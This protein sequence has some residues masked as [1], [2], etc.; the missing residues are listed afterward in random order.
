[1]GHYRE[2]STGR[3]LEAPLPNK[4]QKMLHYIP[5]LKRLAQAFGKDPKVL[6]TGK[7]PAD[8]ALRALISNYLKH[9][10]FNADGY[11]AANPDIAKANLNKQA[12]F[13][14]FVHNGY[15]EGRVG[16]VKFDDAYYL[17]RYKDVAAAIKSG[18]LKSAK[19]HFR[20]RGHDEFR[21]PNASAESEASFWAQALIQPDLIAGKMA[22]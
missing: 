7:A 8:K 17:G 13:N 14:H 12:L 19:D 18:S 1:M 2:F 20:S 4:G 10:D 15:F 3:L 21:C 9:Y 6:A 11:L 5:T 16:Y 22:G